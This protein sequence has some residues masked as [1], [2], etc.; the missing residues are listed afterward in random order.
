MCDMLMKEYYE[1]REVGECRFINHEII[2]REDEA[3]ENHCSL[4]YNVFHTNGKDDHQI[5]LSSL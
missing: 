3:E 1:I 2:T 4:K 5:P